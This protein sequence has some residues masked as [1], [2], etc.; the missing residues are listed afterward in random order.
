MKYCLGLD[1]G[2]NSIGW[3]ILS[4]DHESQPTRIVDLGS[5]IFHDGRDP[6]SGESTAVQR[7]LA[8]QARRNRDR[9]L[10]R[11]KKLLAILTK[12]GLFPSDLQ[13]REKL[14]NLDVYTLRVVALDKKMQAY[15]IGR[16]L[17]HLAQ[18]RGF[19]SG[20]KH[21]ESENQQKENTKLLPKLEDLEKRIQKTSSRTFGEYLLNKVNKRE[22]KRNKSHLEISLHPT[23]RMIEDEFD[24][25]I[26][27][28]KQHHKNLT[29]KLIKEIHHSI[30]YQRHL[31][32][33]EELVG[34]CEMY[35]DSEKR[36]A[37]YLPSIQEFKLLQTIGQLKL[38]QDG[39]NIELTFDQKKAIYNELRKGS[40]K[41][42][43][44]LRMK[45]LKLDSDIEFNLESGTSKSLN[46]SAVNAKFK[47]KDYFGK[48]WLN[49]SL[50]EQDKIVLDIAKADED[51]DKDE[52]KEKSQKWS[53]QPKEKIFDN[54]LLEKLPTGYGRFSYKVAQELCKTFIENNFCRYDQAME[55]LGHKLGQHNIT[56][57]KDKLPY[58]GEVLKRY[59]IPR[60]DKL[61]KNEQDKK[62]RISNPTVHIVL[63]QLRKVVNALIDCHGKPEK[64][65]VELG[66]DLKM[67]KKQKANYEKSQK[68]NQRANE[69]ADQELEKLGFPSHR[70]N[71]IR[72][73]LWKEMNKRMD[74][75][76]Q[77]PYTGKMISLRQAFSGQV[78]IDHILP[79]SKTLD[80]SFANKILAYS[81]ANQTKGNR[82]PF[83][84]FSSDTNKLKE[85]LARVKNFPANKRLRFNEDAMKRFEDEN[86][87]LKRQLNDT[88][89]LSRVAKE[90]VKCLGCQVSVSKGIYTSKVRYNLGLNSILEW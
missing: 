20:R 30:F 76:A 58:Y 61:Q 71:R 50:E 62:G 17:Y 47:G 78:E 65:I 83:E 34:P 11:Q 52:L 74:G 64:I 27:V 24:Q 15:E 87:W 18:R 1:L 68:E 51:E 81:Q 67:N 22:I 84:G 45:T 33:S 19:K 63:N 29:D 25:I 36:G 75:K 9:T 42:F 69:E 48:E 8:R 14:K 43:K 54:D 90:Y 26:K 3:A 46:G 77:C 57:I 13:E 82:S 66:R 79:F 89:Y 35:P 70:E 7:R 16:I 86:E 40:K 5:H 23:R 41:T 80:D 60:P 21:L 37:N 55:I 4:L 10:R 88:R 73:K 12:N 31:K 56:G 59:A 49:L 32:S 6:K 53:L 85:M 2:T 28:Q 72:Y 39:R 44:D 38:I